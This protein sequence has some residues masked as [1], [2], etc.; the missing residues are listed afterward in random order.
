MPTYS[1]NTSNLR[2]KKNQKKRIAKGITDIH[3]KITGANNYFAQV[4]FNETK[5]DPERGINQGL[6]PKR[7]R[8]LKEL[9]EY[10]VKVR[11]RG[12]YYPKSGHSSCHSEHSVQ[13]I[14]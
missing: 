4:L 7:I 13:G 6:F 9:S 8:K 5:K 10:R 12:T 14:V 11:Q 3:S 2:L 1:V